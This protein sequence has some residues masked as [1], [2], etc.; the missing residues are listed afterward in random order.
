MTN[1]QEELTATVNEFAS[2]ANANDLTDKPVT[3]TTPGDDTSKPAVST[4]NK[5]NS[6]VKTGDDLQAGVPLMAAIVSLL[7]IAGARILK[8]KRIEE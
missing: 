5:T 6:S 4:G 3:P 2:K 7:G 1:L 8:R